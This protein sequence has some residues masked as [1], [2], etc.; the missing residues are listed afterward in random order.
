MNVES[1]LLAPA[2]TARDRAHAPYSEFRVGAAVRTDDG[3]VFTGCNVENASSG[4]GVCAERVAI[5]VAIAAGARRL[6]ELAMAVDQRALA[7]RERM[8][9]GACRQV[10]AEHLDVAAPAHVDGVGTFTLQ[11]PLPDPFTF[12]PGS[13]P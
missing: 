9:C 4:L 13:R 3:R 6:V 1:D 10:M 8:T 12:S 11:A 5:F 2:R 7:R